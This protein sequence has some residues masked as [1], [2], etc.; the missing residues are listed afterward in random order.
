MT[1][2]LYRM[3]RVLEYIGTREAIDEAAA[4]RG[5]KDYAH[6]H[7]GLTIRESSI[8]TFAP[9]MVGECQAALHEW[10]EQAEEARGEAFTMN[11]EMARGFYRAVDD[12]KEM[13]NGR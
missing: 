13:L 9:E 4:R 6:P 7:T 2:P 10:V 8:G 12:V 5:V 11:P 1:A 3:V